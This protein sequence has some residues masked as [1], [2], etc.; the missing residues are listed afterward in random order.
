MGLV[1]TGSSIGAVIFPI[2]LE[3]L[4]PQVGFGWAVRALALIQLVTCGIACAVMKS[5]L[6]PRKAGPLV[7]PR[8]FLQTSYTL[9]AVGG[10]LA[11]WGLYTPF[12]YSTSFL[13]TVDGPANLTPYVLSMMNVSPLFYLTD[14][15]PRLSS[16]EFYQTLSP[17]RLDRL[18][19]SS[20]LS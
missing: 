7:E 3:R 14:V 10:F 6:P 8:A 9:F 13:Q 5:R 19:F 2:V 20:Q 15:R 16:G 18:T 17:I 12:F 1:A 4:I 11:F